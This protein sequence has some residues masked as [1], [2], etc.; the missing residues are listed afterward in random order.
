MFLEESPRL[1]AQI[2]EAVAA[3]DEAGLIAPAHSLK[4]WTGN[5]V[6]S[7]AFEAVA[8]LAQV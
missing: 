1:L 7:G 8:N 6:A 4:N 5:F 3:H 2:R